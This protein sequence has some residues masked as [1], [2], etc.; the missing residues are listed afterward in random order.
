MRKLTSKYKEKKNQK[1]NQWIVGIILIFLML[2]S[3]LGFAFQGGFSKK[4]DGNSLIYNGYE[5]ENINGFWAFEDF[6]FKYNPQEVP[7]T[8]EIYFKFS[9]YQNKPLYI[10]S[11]DAESEYEIFLNLGQFTQRTQKAC[12]ENK[13]CEGDIPYKDCENNFIIIK[14]D[15]I[16]NIYQE[17]N[18][19]FIQG[20]EENLIKLVDQFLFKILGVK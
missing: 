4:D 13:I 6:V 12:P 1:R 10:Y 2:V 19:V 16:E 8:G 14:V 20:R 9:D 15:E 7:D 11:E 17:S 3:T 18:C 5:F